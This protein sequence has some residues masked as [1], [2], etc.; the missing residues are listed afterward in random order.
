MKNINILCIFQ[1]SNDIKLIKSFLENQKT[2]KVKESW[3]YQFSYIF[4]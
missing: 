3:I 2:I 4:F 1:L